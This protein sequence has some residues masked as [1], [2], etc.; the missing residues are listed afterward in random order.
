MSEQHILTVT[1]QGQFQATYLEQLSNREFWDYATQLAGAPSVPA[2]PI[3]SY[4]ECSLLQGQAHAI[5]PLSSLRK[6]IP[7]PHHVTRLPTTPLW[8]SGLTAWRS[9]PIPVIDLDSYLTR[10]SA[11]HGHDATL[12]VAQQDDVVLGLLVSVV[13]SLTALEPERLLPVQQPPAWCSN[14]PPHL[15]LSTYGDA[16]VFNLSAMLIDMIQQMRAMAVYE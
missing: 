13:G 1:L 16:L 15:L 6:V 12:L 14:L 8:M 9:E 11:Y 5:F 4:L 2:R 10:Q 7:P 3:E